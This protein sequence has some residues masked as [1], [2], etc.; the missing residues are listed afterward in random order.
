MATA[1]P[2]PD[3]LAGRTISFKPRS[4]WV[5]VLS[6][7]VRRKPLGLV[8]AIL[9]LVLLAVALAAATTALVRAFV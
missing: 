3:L 9:V 2:T 6:R 8:G 5:D 4:F 1:A 7:R